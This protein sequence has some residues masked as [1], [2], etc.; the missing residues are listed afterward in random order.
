MSTL[1][2]IA[3]LSLLPLCGA[4]RRTDMTRTTTTTTTIITGSGWVSV[5]A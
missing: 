4:Q 3:S 5:R 2:A 1:R